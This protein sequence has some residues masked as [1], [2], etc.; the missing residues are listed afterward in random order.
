MTFIYSNTRLG[1]LF[2]GALT[3][4]SGEINTPKVRLG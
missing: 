4:L 2:R 3:G 1:G